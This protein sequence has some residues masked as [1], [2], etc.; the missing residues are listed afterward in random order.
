MVTVCG[1]RRRPHA[2]QMAAERKQALALGLSE[3]AWLLS[4]TPLHL[5]HGV[6]EFTQPSFPLRLQAA[7]YQPIVRIK[8]GAPHLM[9]EICMSSSMSGVWRRSQGVNH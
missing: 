4:L 3:T 2:R 9:R 5:S 7:R 8:C 1:G 6:A